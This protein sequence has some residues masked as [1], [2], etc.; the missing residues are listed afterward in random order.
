MVKRALL[1]TAAWLALSGAACAQSAYNQQPGP[2]VP[3][4]TGGGGGGSGTVTS[5]TA[6]SGLTGG[7]ITT[8]GTIAVNPALTL[9]TP[10]L[11][12]PASGVLTHATGLPLTTGVTG[13]LPVTNLN[14]GTSASSST[15]WRGDA[16]WSTPS[17]AGTVTSVATGV[18]LTGGPITSS[19]TIA[20]T[21]N[22]NA[23]IGTSYTVS[24][25]DSCSLITFNNASAIAVALPQANSTGFTPP[26]GFD[27]QNLGAG[28]ITVTPATSTING[29]ATLT[30]SQN[31]GCEIT[32]DGVNYQVSL[33][34]ALTGGTV[35]SVAVTSSDLTVGGSPITGSGSISLTL[36]SIVSAATGTKITA[37]AKGQVT[38]IAN[39]S[40]ASADFVNQGT[41]TTV[42]HGNA[43]GNPSFGAV[44]LGTDVTSNLPVANLNSGTSA[45]STTFWRGDATWATPTA[46]GS[47]DNVQSFTSNGTWTKPANVTHVSVLVCGAGGG[48]GSGAQ[49]TLGTVG[50]GGGGGGGGGCLFKEFS[51]SEFGSTVTIT[52]GSGGTAGAATT[53][54]GAG[55]VGGVGGDSSFGTTLKAYAGGGGGGGQPAASSAGG[56]SAGCA[57]DGGTASGSTGGTGAGCGS[58]AGVAAGA[59]GSS[60]ANPSGGGSGGGGSI[61]T[62][63]NGPIAIWCP[64]AP[65]G[66]TLLAATATNGGTGGS[67]PGISGAS[68]GSNTGGNG[69][70]GAALSATQTGTTGGGGGANTTGAGGSPGTSAPCA[71]GAGSGPGIVNGVAG[72]V[73]GTGLVVV[74]SW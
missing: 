73:G 17:G 40:L 25:S 66:G 28:L 52:V 1:A 67:L 50:T 60:G 3:P 63:F 43:A 62:G 57:G 47:N 19:G 46:P 30:I 44:N 68:G 18:C 48:G 45:S 4:S 21:W 31:T 16:T 38:A 74:R 26:F 55:N 34:T 6:G 12:T 8:S 5:I 41:T 37:N 32:S 35:T 7:T 70:N 2:G 58:V 59:G 11:G 65:S 36:P 61:T 27:V 23:Q 64:G 9:T 72:A 15:Y 13:N 29:L 69:G 39:A 14:S 24:A 71:G 20:S 53:G 10:T 56:A 51:A 33:C 49:E 42:L 54:V 22:I